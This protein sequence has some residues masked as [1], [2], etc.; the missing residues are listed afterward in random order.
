MVNR[1]SKFNYE[2]EL[3]ILTN[4]PQNEVSA[5]ASW[6]SFEGPGRFI[7]GQTA[8][9]VKAQSVIYCCNQPDEKIVPHEVKMFG[10]FNVMSVSDQ[11][12]GMDPEE[13][14]I[15]LMF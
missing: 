6:F 13:V 4:T 10:F 3:N 9:S 15:S 14:D 1:K 12:K 5:I 7:R 2:V 8:V 11:I